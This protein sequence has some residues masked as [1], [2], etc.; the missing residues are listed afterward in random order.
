MDRPGRG[1]ADDVVGIAR[2]GPA[3]FGQTFRHPAK[4]PDLVGRARTA[5]GQ[6]QPRFLSMQHEND[7][8]RIVLMEQQR[9]DC[10]GP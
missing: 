5:A 7:Y 3:G 2:P 6:D 10:M 9:R 4:H 1:S 8:T